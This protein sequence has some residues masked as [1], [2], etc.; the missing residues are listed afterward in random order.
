[1]IKLNCEIE[2]NKHNKGGKYS[3]TKHNESNKFSSNKKVKENQS[4][5]NSFFNNFP[6]VTWLLYMH[7]IDFYSRPKRNQFLFLP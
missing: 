2:Y 6:H 3:I 7:I 4:R 5:K 1:M